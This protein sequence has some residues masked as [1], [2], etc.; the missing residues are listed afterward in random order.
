MTFS[1]KLFKKETHMI[2]AKQPLL[3]LLDAAHIEY[4]LHEHPAVFT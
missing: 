2:S 3:T 4:K 1:L